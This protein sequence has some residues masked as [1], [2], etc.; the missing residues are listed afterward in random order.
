LS[1]RHLNM[2]RIES[3]PTKRSL[4]EYLFFIDLEANANHAEV[5]VALQEIDAQTEHLRFLGSYDVID[6]SQSELT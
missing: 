1:K 6:L 4:G 3:R 2:S 5:Q